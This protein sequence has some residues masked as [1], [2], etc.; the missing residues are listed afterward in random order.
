MRHSK[1]TIPSKSGS[2]PATKVYQPDS[3]LA[4]EI[5]D[6]L[7]ASYLSTMNTSRGAIITLSSNPKPASDPQS[8][9]NEVIL[10]RRE[11]NRLAQKKHRT[12]PNLTSISLG[13]PLDRKQSERAD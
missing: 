12:T 9:A 3:I 1:G 10:R 11:Q 7:L 8:E 2:T 4:S 13:S 5:G 6:S